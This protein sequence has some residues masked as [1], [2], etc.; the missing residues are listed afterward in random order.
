MSES[1]ERKGRILYLDF[2]R[3]IA[4]IGVM[5][6][7]FTGKV[8]GSPQIGES[9]WFVYVALNSLEGLLCHFIL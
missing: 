2:L 3:T 7:H 1:D 9:G 4:V 8:L 6:I 5:L